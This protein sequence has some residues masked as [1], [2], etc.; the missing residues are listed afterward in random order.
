VT[1][2][3][4]RNVG[5][6][7]TVELQSIVAGETGV[8]VDDVARQRRLRGIRRR[9]KVERSVVRGRDRQ[10]VVAAQLETDAMGERAVVGGAVGR[11]AVERLGERVGV[12]SVAVVREYG[13]IGRGILGVRLQCAVV[14][15]R[16]IG[17][18]RVALSWAARPQ[19]R[20]CKADVVRGSARNGWPSRRAG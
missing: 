12:R 16:D 20:D 11:I 18:P 1:G 2:D 7:A 8:V 6:R 19:L 14:Q 9:H 5:A 15:P 3:A 13:A 4:V 17:V 10:R